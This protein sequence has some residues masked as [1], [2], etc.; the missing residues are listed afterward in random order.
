MGNQNSKRPSSKGNRNS[1]IVDPNTHSQHSHIGSSSKGTGAPH[2]SNNT[3]QKQ[4]QPLTNG[5]NATDAKGQKRSSKDVGRGSWLPQAPQNSASVFSAKANPAH[6]ETTPVAGHHDQPRTSV[7]RGAGQGSANRDTESAAAGAAGAGGAAKVSSSVSSSGEQ[8]SRHLYAQ[9]QSRHSLDTIAQGTNGSHYNHIKNNG[10]RVNSHPPPQ[11]QTPTLT[12]AEA[13]TST[14]TEA[15]AHAGAP[16]HPDGP[17]SGNHQNNNDTHSGQSS[18]RKQPEQQQEQQ[19][20]PS[21]YPAPSIPFA[22]ASPGN[23]ILVKKHGLAPLNITSSYSSP[24]H[25]RSPP[26]PQLS[27]KT[28]GR[29]SQELSPTARLSF[30]GPGTGDKNS[31]SKNMD[32]DDMISRLLDAGYSGK[33]SKSICLKNS[34][35]LFICHQA[36]EAFLS[37]PTLIELNAPVKIVGDIHGQYTDLLRLFEMCG[38]PPSANF[39]FLGD[40]VDRGRMSLETILLLFC[41]KIKYPENFFLLRGNHE[42]ANVTKVYGFYDECKRR[43]SIKMWKA[44][45]DVFNCLPLAGI[46]ANKI[47][48]VHGGLSPSLSTMDDIRALRRPTDVPDY[49]LLNDL[50]WSDPSDTTLDWEDNERGVSYCFG[51]SI[52]Q[53]FLNK[54]DFDLVCRAHM[55]VEDGYEFFNDRTLVTVFSAPNYCGEFDNFGAVMSVNEDLLC[56][57]ELLKPIDQATAR[58]QMQILAASSGGWRVNKQRLSIPDSNSLYGSSR[59]SVVN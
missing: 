54:H 22:V 11:T 57:F 51:R 37:Q 24:H 15:Q 49:G 58:A 29:K 55:V 9:E 32:I 34:E 7:D 56:S 3:Q 43:A 13:Q 27:P 38:F 14:P 48:C 19:H 45:V 40:Y 25:N 4:Q 5:N 44:F 26:P 20:Q 33:I 59:T 41:Y 52:I 35:I 18:P 12:Q 1:A 16:S 28:A 8:G 31:S 53:K 42:C 36:R 47:F 46:V 23:P 17:N 10:S 2:S 39:L 21:S 50:L 30:L 6:D